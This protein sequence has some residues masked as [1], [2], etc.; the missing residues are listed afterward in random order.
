MSVDRFSC[1]FVD[2]NILPSVEDVM[3]AIELLHR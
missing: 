1:E 2:T 3:E